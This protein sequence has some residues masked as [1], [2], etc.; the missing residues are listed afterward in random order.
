MSSKKESTTSTSPYRQAEGFANLLG[1]EER[2]VGCKER[3]QASYSQI[4]R[5][6]KK[7][8]SVPLHTSKLDD[9]SVEIRSK[10]AWIGGK[11]CGVQRKIPSK[12]LPDMQEA[13]EDSFR[14][15]PHV[16]A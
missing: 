8:R 1:L 15:A 3:F 4:C 13:E 7:T 16:Q 2:D 14:T 10:S 5:R 11:G 9:G 6:Q 12:L